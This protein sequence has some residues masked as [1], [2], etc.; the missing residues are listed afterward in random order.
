MDTS[1]VK[2]FHVLVGDSIGPFGNPASPEKPGSA[3]TARW[4]YPQSGRPH[5]AGTKM[6]S[7]VTWFNMRLIVRDYLARWSEKNVQVRQ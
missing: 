3:E 1:I 5:G 6:K 7:C 4:H 2:R